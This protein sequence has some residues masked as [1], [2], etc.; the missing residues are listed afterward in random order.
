MF[1]RQGAIL[2][3]SQIQKSTRA[4]TSIWEVRC[5][6]SLKSNCVHLLVNVIACNNNVRNA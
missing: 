2:S 3:K 1:R 5:T 4:N 6:Y